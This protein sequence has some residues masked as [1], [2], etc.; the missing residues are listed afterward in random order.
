MRSRG[1]I[2]ALAMVLAATATLA[3]YLYIQGIQ[4]AAESGGERVSV[5][6][7]TEDVPAGATLNDLISEGLFTKMSV[8][9]DLVVPGAVTSLTRLD[10]RET[11]AGIL[12]GEQISSAR[13][14]GSSGQLP[15]GSLGIPEGHQALTIPLEPA[16]VAGGAV[17]SG[18]H[19]TLFATFSGSGQ[20]QNAATVALVPDAKVLEVE[21]PGEGNGVGEGRNDLLLIT[22]ALEPRDGQ[23]VVF[24]LEQGSIWLSLLAPEQ[25]GSP[26]PP[27]SFSEVIE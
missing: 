22:L 8:P 12:A 13:L 10:G 6:V 14:R 17:Q 24:A 7:A 19:V 1:T 2:V 27:V 18:D 23:K 26:Q 16:R 21:E 25:S 9:Q 11:S 15:G 4:A 5:I 3:V 20:A